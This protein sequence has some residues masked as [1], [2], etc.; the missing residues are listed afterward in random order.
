MLICSVWLKYFHDHFFQQVR[1]RLNKSNTVLLATMNL[2]QQKIALKKLN[3]DETILRKEIEALT[4]LG[5]GNIVKIFGWAK[6]SD[7]RGILTEYVE[8]DSLKTGE[9][10]RV[11]K[12][13]V[14]SNN[15][16]DVCEQ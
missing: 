6:E 12:S 7:W 2:N 11:D 5:C 8:G 15:W 16:L 13:A 3:V 1:E 10:L 14:C 9:C 4:L